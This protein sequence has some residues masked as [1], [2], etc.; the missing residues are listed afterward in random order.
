ML[1]DVLVVTGTGGIGRAVLD[2]LAAGRN[3]LIGDLNPAALDEVTQALTARGHHVAAQ[4]L[5]VSD[6]HSVAAFAQ[7]ADSLGPVKIVV[8]TAGVAPAEADIA[9]ILRVDYLG[10]AL[11]T[12]AF[13]KII[14]A[15]GAGVVMS[16]IAADFS[17]PLDSAEIMALASTPTEALMNLPL[18]DPQR[19]VPHSLAY[20][21]SKMA[22]RIRV[23][24][25]AMVW[26]QR[27]ARLNAVSPGAIATPMGA[28]ELEKDGDE[29]PLRRL[30]RQSAITRIGSP[31]DI[32]Q[33]VAFLVGPDAAFI[34]GSNLHVDGGMIGAFIA[35][36]RAW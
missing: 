8:H 14:A 5:D 27:G 22:N 15:G 31:E 2:R 7:R 33:A 4:Q 21:F 10:T 29:N 9:R 24:G 28:R 26:A 36:G 20:G 3:V 34:T 30:M 6:P 32:A 16:S 11:V 35:R 19:F 25:D 13:G 23:A 17:P 12:E 18:A 1:E